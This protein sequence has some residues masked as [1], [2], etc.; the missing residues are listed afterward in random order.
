MLDQNDLFRNLFSFGRDL[1]LSRDF[2]RGGG[3]SGIN[4]QICATFEIQRFHVKH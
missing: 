3:H 2:Y 4:S 1:G